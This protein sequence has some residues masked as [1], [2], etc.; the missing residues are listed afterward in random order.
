[1]KHALFTLGSKV[2]QRLGY[3]AIR[4][5]KSL[6]G[7]S[8][9]LLG[10][11]LLHEVAVMHM[12]RDRGCRPFR[13]VQV[14]A[15]EMEGHYDIVAAAKRFG[16]YQGVLIDAQPLVIERL[17]AKYESDPSLTVLH[18]AVTDTPGEVDFHSVAN[19]DRT[20][21]EWVEGLAS[22]SRANILKFERIVPGL[23]SRIV[24][25]RVKT[26]SIRE[27]L[28]GFESKELDLL[29]IDAEGHDYQI[30]KTFPFEESRPAIVFLEHCHLS[31][32][33]RERAVDAL[34]SHGYRVAC[35]ESDLLASR[36]P[37]SVLH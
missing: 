36:Q 29:M 3:R 22:L 15:L 7:N 4:Y 21:P 34:V 13:F 5:P 24:T 14:G 20:L 25:N 12:W 27:V 9:Q 19:Q 8:S 26:I 23:A 30:L 2:L 1:M 31:A 16:E 6:Q 11:T 18:R 37:E 10:L 17:M 32:V 28:R 33:E 35:L